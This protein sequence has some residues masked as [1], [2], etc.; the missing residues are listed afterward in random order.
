MTPPH[1]S[2]RREILALAAAAGGVLVAYG[3]A[4]TGGRAPAAAAPPVQ[5]YIDAHSHVWTAD[6]TPFPLGPWITSDHMDP[7]DFTAERLLALAEPHGVGRVVLI[8]HAPY[9]GDDNSYLIDCARRFPGRFAVVAVVDERRDDLADHLRHLKDQGVRGLRI[10][11]A[12]YADRTMVRDPARWLEAAAMRSLWARATELNLVLCPLVSA[13]YLPTLDPVLA[14]FADA[15][16]AIDHFG[17][18]QTPDE[19]QAL[20]KL[21]RHRNVHV[22]ASGFYKFGDRKAPYDDL[23]SMI[24]TVTDAFGPDRLLWGSDCPYQ[25]QAGNNYGDAVSLVA[26][27]LDFLSPADRGAILRDNAR[28]LFFG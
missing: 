5:G 10:G 3:C 2:T 24:R 18:A 11:P 16:V 23:S 4:S 9:Y 26:R 20:L 14:E 21:A 7:P 15:R 6:T 28:R 27:G 12:R 13:E 25:L 17:N 22:K 1:P 19:L 8:Q